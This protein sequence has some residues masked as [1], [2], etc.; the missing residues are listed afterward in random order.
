MLFLVEVK[1]IKHLSSR[2]TLLKRKFIPV[3]LYQVLG[4]GFAVS[5]ALHKPNIQYA[6]WRWWNT[7]H[8][9][10]FRVMDSS[11]M[12]FSEVNVGKRL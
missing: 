12:R 6:G 10:N 11:S 3:G 7:G 9:I 1:E 4:F 8:D 5:S 2:E